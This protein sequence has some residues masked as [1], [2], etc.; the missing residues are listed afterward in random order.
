MVKRELPKNPD[1]LATILDYS[2]KDQELLY[3][4][5]RHPS[6][7]YEKDNLG[8]SDNQRLEFLGDAVISLAISHLLME[9]F[10]EMKEGDLSKY[11]ASLVSENGLSCIAQELELGDYLLLGKG[12]ERTNGR[13]KLSIQSDALEALI[14]A[15]YLDGGFV[16]ALRVIAKL[17][18]PLL[19]RISLDKSINDFKTE[20]QEYS[21]ETFQSTPE[22]RLEKET[23][24][25]HNK[26]FYVG[27]HL[28][29][30]LMGE[31]KGKSKKE[32]EQNAAKEALACLK[33]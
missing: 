19:N 20:L 3:Q 17:F 26:T 18:S 11:R 8:V 21:Q 33:K 14:G 32:A 5:F 31:G 9:F 25:D 28:K 13:K 23:G 10:P 27:V 22:Y 30:N 4:A 24:P 12:E 1:D 15:I 6:Y 16:E 7:V 2:F 29:G